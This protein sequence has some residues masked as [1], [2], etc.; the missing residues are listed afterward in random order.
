[1]NLCLQCFIVSNGVQKDDFQ[2][3]TGFRRSCHNCLDE[4]LTLKMSASFSWHG[5]ELE[6]IKSHV[7]TTRQ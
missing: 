2:T 4:G 3:L 7:L 1:M 5:G 6:L